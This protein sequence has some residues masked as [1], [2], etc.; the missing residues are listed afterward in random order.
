MTIIRAGR[1]AESGSLVDLR[2][3]ARTSVE[4]ELTSAPNGLAALPGVHELE[5]AG[6]RVRG[7]VDSGALDGFLRELTSYGVRSLV[8]R[9]P[10]L[11]ELFLEEYRS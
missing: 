8:S 10:T 11:E 9:P 2:T 3:R 5:V 1:T 4:A 7:Q 6:T